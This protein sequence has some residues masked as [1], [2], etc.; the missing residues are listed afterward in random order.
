[1]T[2]S[3][4]EPKVSVL[5]ISYNEKEYLSQAVNSALMQN[6]ANKEIIIGDDGSEDGSV[7]LIEQL[8]KSGGGIRYFVMSRNDEPIIPSIRVSN[9]IKR[10]LDEAKGEYFT[11][12]SGDDYYVNANMLTEAVDFLEKHPKYV[13]YV[14]GFQ[15]VDK[16]GKEIETRILQNRSNKIYWSGS[17]AHISCFVFR[18]IDS[19]ELLDRMC[20]DTGLEYILAGKGKWGYG[21]NIVIAYRQRESSIQHKADPIELSILEM[22][23]YQDILNR[24]IDELRYATWSRFYKSYCH[25]INNRSVLKDSK[26]QKYISSCAELDNDVIRQIINGKRPGFR[27]WLCNRYY[28]ALRMLMKR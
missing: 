3:E 1:M 28:A 18:K 23:I 26:Y 13:A 20:D 11:I 14:S 15:R 24:P 19:S 8:V 25:L 22:M 16:Q 17:Y 10:G 27:M 4:Q 9:V 5:I 2:M 6:Y 12:L 21:S 7:G